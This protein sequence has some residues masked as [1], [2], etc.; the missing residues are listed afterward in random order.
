MTAV[1]IEIQAIKR[2]VAEKDNMLTLISRVETE[3]ALMRK[4][5]LRNALELGVLRA[6]DEQQ[7]GHLLSPLLIRQFF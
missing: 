7:N 2:K 3:T 1:T 5:I 6:L 4:D